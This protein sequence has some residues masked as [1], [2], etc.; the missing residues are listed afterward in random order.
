MSV[1][2]ISQNR[3][4]LLENVDM[5]PLCSGSGVGRRAKREGVCYVP[6][7]WEKD[8]AH[9][10]TKGVNAKQTCLTHAS[11]S[12]VMALLSKILPPPYDP[13]THT[14]STVPLPFAHI[15]CPPAQAAALRRRVWGTAAPPNLEGF[16]INTEPCGGWGLQYCVSG[17]TDRPFVIH[18]SSARY[19]Y[20]HTG[21]Q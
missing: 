8:S 6:V 9:S 10:C 19:A 18:C 11:P 1:E 21:I 5:R 7:F 4:G 3:E 20:R 2:W 12:A 13:P 15:H 17:Q 16:L 14:H